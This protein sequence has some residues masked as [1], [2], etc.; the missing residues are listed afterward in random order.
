ME[1]FNTNP[2]ER[3]MITEEVKNLIMR[4]YMYWVTMNSLEGKYYIKQLL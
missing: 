3:E 1:S 4:A 2:T